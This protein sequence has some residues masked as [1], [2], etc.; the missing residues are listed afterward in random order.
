[1]QS[2]VPPGE[3][4]PSRPSEVC[5]ESTVPPKADGW[6]SVVV[7]VPAPGSRWMSLGSSALGPVVVCGV[8]YILILD[9]RA[10]YAVDPAV[11]VA[12]WTDR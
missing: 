1:M 8:A 11:S 5:V 9:V 4:S 3:T 10:A 6:P 12:S 7:Q 2:S